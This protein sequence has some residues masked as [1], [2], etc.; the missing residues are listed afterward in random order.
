MKTLTLRELRNR[1]ADVMDAVADGEIFRITRNG[2]EVAELRPLA[3]T[4]RLSAEELVR[5]H[6]RLPRVDGALTRREAD[7]F[8]GDDDRAGDDDPWERARG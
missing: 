2:T 7:E 1:S 3:R 4:R 6:R 8:F 5:R